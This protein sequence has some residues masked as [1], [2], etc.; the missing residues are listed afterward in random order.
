MGKKPLRII[1]GFENIEQK[2]SR[3]KVLLT[4]LRE[5]MGSIALLDMD[6]GNKAVAKLKGAI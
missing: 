1:L 3:L 4:K 6:Y 2:L 5:N